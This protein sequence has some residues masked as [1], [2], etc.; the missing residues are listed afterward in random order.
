MDRFYFCESQKAQKD[1]SVKDTG[2]WIRSLTL[3]GFS[4]LRD[5]L[6]WVN[7]A[8]CVCVCD[9]VC[10]IAQSEQFLVNVDSNVV[11]FLSSDIIACS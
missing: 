1:N 11:T 9:C 3:G 8:V 2:Y 5:R 10:G 7:Q 4:L 6:K